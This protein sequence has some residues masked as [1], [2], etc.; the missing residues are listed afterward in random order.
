M[1]LFLGFVLCIAGGAVLSCN[2]LGFVQQRGIFRSVGLNL[3]I[4]IVMGCDLLGGGLFWYGC[5]LVLGI[6]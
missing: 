2:T 1:S 3:Q 5:N 4:G 6:Y